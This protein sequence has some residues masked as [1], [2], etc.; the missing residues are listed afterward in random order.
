MKIILD[1]TRTRTGIEDSFYTLIFN[2]G[3]SICNGWKNEKEL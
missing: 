1:T 3:I 2:Q